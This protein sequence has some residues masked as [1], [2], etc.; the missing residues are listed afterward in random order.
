MD[1]HTT[2]HVRI[3]GK[4]GKGNVARNHVIRGNQRNGDAISVLLK[5]C[6]VKRVVAVRNVVHANVASLIVD[7]D[8]VVSETARDR[9]QIV[10]VRLAVN[11][12]RRGNIKE[13]AS[14]MLPSL[15]FSYLILNEI[16]EERETENRFG[17]SVASHQ[18]EHTHLHAHIT[19]V[20]G[21]HD[22]VIPV[23]RAILNTQ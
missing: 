21:I 6:L 1:F 3:A 22:D 15:L 7:A 11:G 20:H 18:N 19:A 9:R 14:P 8:R 17:L 10:H 23:S 5:Q 13:V 4:R 12:E 2:K 16:G